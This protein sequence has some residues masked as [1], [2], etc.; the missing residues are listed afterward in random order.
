MKKS[1]VFVGL[2]GIAV[3]LVVCQ[4]SDRTQSN[5]TSIPVRVSAVKKVKIAQPIRTSGRLSSASEIKLSF[6][7]GG[8]IDNVLV[9]EGQ[10]VQKGQILASLKLDEIEGQVAQARAGFEKAERDFRRVQNLYADSAVTLEQLQN[11]KSGL[12]IAESNLKI[13]EFNLSH[14]QISA[15]SRGRILKQL[16]EAGELV[17]PG[18]PILFFGSQSG[19]W[20]VKA[21]VADQD[22]IRIAIGD[23]ASVGF[24]AYPEMC[25]P[26]SV[27]EIA[28]GPDPQNGLY[29]IEL[30]LC[31]SSVTLFS[32]FVAKVDIFSSQTEMVFQV[33]FASLVNVHGLHG[34][35][36]CVEKDS[37]ARKVPV[38]I[39]YFTDENAMIR[40][41]L[42][43]VNFVVTEGAAYLN[44]NKKVKIVGGI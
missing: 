8:I 7:I 42:E 25:F 41:G 24:D 4:R 16:A 18:Q 17:G 26:A 30:E 13:T 12:I 9:D 43:E 27:R 19:C 32:G 23:S 2:L 1:F 44:G 11:A 34:Y 14:A 15:P 37:L 40:K 31:P 6:K 33:P 39:T 21:G 22:L 29:E 10:Q 5:E 20:M 35:V 36:Y 28:A 3:F 38:E